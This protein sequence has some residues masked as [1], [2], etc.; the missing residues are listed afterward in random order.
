MLA[1]VALA[2]AGPELAAE[3]PHATVVAV[4]STNAAIE[5]SPVRAVDMYGTLRLWARKRR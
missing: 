1:G 2:G 4:M 3:L 5:R